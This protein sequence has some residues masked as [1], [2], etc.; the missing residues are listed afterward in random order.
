MC[1]LYLNKMGGE[2]EKNKNKYWV[3]KDF[4]YIKHSTKRCPNRSLF[5]QRTPGVI[6]KHHALTAEI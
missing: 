1:Q 4:I 5:C 6:H 2:M 3:N